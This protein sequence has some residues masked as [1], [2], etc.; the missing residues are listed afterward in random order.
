MSGHTVTLLTLLH[1]LVSLCSVWDGFASKDSIGIV[2]K[3]YIHKKVVIF[4]KDL[5]EKVFH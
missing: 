5:G 4:I 3:L 2:R 1:A